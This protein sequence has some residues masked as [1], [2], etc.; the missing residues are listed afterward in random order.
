M[1]GESFSVRVKLTFHMRVRLII[2]LFLILFALGTAAR[3]DSRHS[4]VSKKDRQA[5]ALEF[6][7]ALDLQKAGQ[8]EE[9]LQAADHA[10]QLFPGNPEYVTAREALRQQL[11]SKLLTQGNRLAEAG[12]LSGAQAQFRQALSIDPENTYVQ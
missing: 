7:R 6:K 10:C 4:S 8:L 1:A 3:A 5:A 9:A 11:V 12:N 2:L